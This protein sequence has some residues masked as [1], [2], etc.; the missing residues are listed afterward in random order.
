MSK[1][2]IYS[3]SDLFFTSWPELDPRTHAIV[4]LL[5]QDLKALPLSGDGPSYGFRLIQILRHL[6]KNPALVNKIKTEE[7]A[8]DIFNSLDFLAKP[9]Y[10]FPLLPT[11]ILAKKPDEYMARHT[12]DHFIYADNEYS[13]FLST[14]DV[15][16][17]RRLVVTLYSYPGEE[18]FEKE[19]VARRE[20]VIAKHID[21]WQLNLVFFTYAHVREFVTKRCK[22][23]LPVMASSGP[24]EEVKEVKV[25]PTGALWLKVKHRLAETPAFSGYDAAGR[26][27]M[28]S[29]LDY[30]E[31]LAQQKA[32][33]KH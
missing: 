8:V 29:A 14:R 26:A 33:A 32:N 4:Y 15:K 2:K 30:L 17:L 11:A 12:F 21:D 19:D 3:V 13:S 7:Q 23:L 6:R 10:F 16:Y 1:Q 5:Y 31:D 20:T 18:H 22:T 25:M 9:W 28:F 27:N 24:D